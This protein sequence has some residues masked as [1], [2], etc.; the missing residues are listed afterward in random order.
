MVWASA[1]AGH[2]SGMMLGWTSRFARRSAAITAGG[3]ASGAS[4]PVPTTTGARLITSGAGRTQTETVTLGGGLS[5]QL[6][7]PLFHVLGAV[8]SPCPG[9]LATRVVLAVVQAAVQR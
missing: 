8:R 7:V 3:W 4:A 9:A 5:S 2:S 1:L 6:P